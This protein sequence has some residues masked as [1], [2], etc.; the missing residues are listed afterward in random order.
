MLPG[1]LFPSHLCLYVLAL[2]V[3]RDGVSMSCSL[4]FSSLAS[5]SFDNNVKEWRLFADII[6]DVGLTLGR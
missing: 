2:Q 1:H 6:N 5:L 3:F 4:C